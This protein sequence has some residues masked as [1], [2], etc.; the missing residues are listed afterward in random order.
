MGLFFVVTKKS[1]QDE[2][3]SEI[4]QSRNILS[5]AHSW[6]INQPVN[7]RARQLLMHGDAFLNP[8][9]TIN[10]LISEVKVKGRIWIM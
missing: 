2:D 1:K 9:P 8:I 5:L 7:V 10:V 6:M 4:K 3:L